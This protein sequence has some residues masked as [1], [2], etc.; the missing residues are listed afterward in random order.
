MD[1]SEL[2]N[3]L[4]NEIK[5]AVSI[6]VDQVVSGVSPGSLLA[7]FP[8]AVAVIGYAVFDGMETLSRQI[9]R[10]PSRVVAQIL[11]AQAAKRP[12]T[13][14]VRL[15]Q[16]AEFASRIALGAV[17][18]LSGDIPPP[19]VHTAVRL[20]K[21]KGIREALLRVGKKIL[22]GPFLYRIF[23]LLRAPAGFVIRFVELF[24]NLIVVVM[25]VG[26]VVVLWSIVEADWQSLALSQKHRRHRERVKINRR[27]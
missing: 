23:A 20:T 7:P 10:I 22:L 17:F 3:L 9:S 15:D 21:I 27:L 19:G 18:E 12:K 26:G 6:S 14:V 4:V 11:V 8:I 24:W 2:V 1:Q 25:G 16:A 5:R 13:M